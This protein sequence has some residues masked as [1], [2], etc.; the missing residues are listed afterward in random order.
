MIKKFHISHTVLVVSVASLLIG[1]ASAAYVY[2][3]NISPTAT[4][5]FVVSPRYRALPPTLFPRRIIFILLVRQPTVGKIFKLDQEQFISRIKPLVSKPVSRYK[6]AH[7][8]SMG[9]IHFVSEIVS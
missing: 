7:C 3:E 4:P 5:E 2:R 8:C 6:M 1:L 9:R